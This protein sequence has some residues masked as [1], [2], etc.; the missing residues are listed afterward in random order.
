MTP[1]E[2]IAAIDEKS[3]EVLKELSMEPSDVLLALMNESAMRGFDLG[4]KMASSMY[5]GAL[6]V[7]LASL[8]K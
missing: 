8:K 6:R 1:E 4:A 5:E 2:V 3:R 7:K